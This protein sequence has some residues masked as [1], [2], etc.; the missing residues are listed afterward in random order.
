MAPTFTRNQLIARRVLTWIIH[1]G[2]RLATRLTVTGREHIP[3]QGPL[4]VV[5]NHVSTMDAILLVEA[6][7]GTKIPENQLFFV[8]PGDFKLQFPGNLVV[9]TT[10]V[11]R[12]KRSTKT[13]LSNLKTMGEVLRGGNAICMF[14]EGGTWEK[15]IWD[16][17]PG[18]AYLSMTT[19]AAILPMGFSNT[20][21]IWAKVVRL[22][23]PEIQI[24]IG[25]VIPPIEQPKERSKRNEVL[26]TAM[27]HIMRTIYDLIPRADQA[28]YDDW[29]ARQYHLRAERWDGTS[30]TSATEIEIADSA[31]LS[32]ILQKPNLMEPFVNIAKLPIRP[33][34]QSGKRLAAGTLREAANALLQ[35]LL[36]TAPFEDYF[37]YRLGEAK[38]AQIRTA[39][40]ALIEVAT[41]HPEAT[42]ALHLSS[43]LPSTSAATP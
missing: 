37:E 19:N 17:K 16:A 38:A 23:R 13:D 12:L 42:F 11:I 22:Q 3:A 30:A 20:Y 33:L 7:R 43:T 8:G 9:E 40:Q 31:V 26:A 5:A 34:F 18:V 39:L 29:A 21:R 24:Q 35:V 36:P 41:A 6:M 4:L 25:P 27:Q 32:E 2:L 28:R 10:G 14:P 15:S 1:Y